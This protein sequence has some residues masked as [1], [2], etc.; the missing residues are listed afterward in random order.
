LFGAAS[1]AELRIG[2]NCRETQLRGF[3]KWLAAGFSNAIQR[4]E[5]GRKTRH[6]DWIPGAICLEVGGAA[7]AVDLPGVGQAAIAALFVR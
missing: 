1:Q 5:V 4:K 2:T 6:L 7:V 3:K